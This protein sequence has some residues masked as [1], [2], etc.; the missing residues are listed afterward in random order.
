MTNKRIQ[1]DVFPP[2]F[3]SAAETK[4][5]HLNVFTIHLSYPT[6]G[7]S[8]G[9][10]L[11]VYFFV[12]GIRSITA[13]IFGCPSEDILGDWFNKGAKEEHI[14]GQPLCQSRALLVQREKQGLDH[15]LAEDSSL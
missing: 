15:G 13:W 1:G 14:W 4:I 5:C 8:N 11:L 7:N 6:T 9:R 3:S 10:I 12:S 2:L